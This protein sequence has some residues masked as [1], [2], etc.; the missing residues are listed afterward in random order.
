MAD[1]FDLAAKL[2]R[3]KLEISDNLQAIA[4]EMAN[5]AKAIAQRNII[6][7]GFGADYSDHGVP[8]FWQKG[9]GLNK[10]GNS[11]IDKQ[12]AAGDMDLPWKEIREAQ[13]M[14]TDH[15]DLYYSGDMFQNMVVVETVIQGYAATGRIGGKTDTAQDKMNWNYD[16]YG[17]FI[18]KALPEADRLFIKEI[19]GDKINE[20]LKQIGL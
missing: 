4:A 9:R 3:I 1:L 8:A 2:E 16:R 15:V 10:A 6:D 18:N 14:P 17:D 11:F 5:S 7:H 13:G 19:A 20:I 12:I